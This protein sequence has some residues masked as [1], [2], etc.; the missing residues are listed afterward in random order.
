[1]KNHHNDVLLLKTKKSSEKEFKL[2]K[3]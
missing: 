2:N 3:L 1:M